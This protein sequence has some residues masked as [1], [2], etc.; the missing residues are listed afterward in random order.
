MSPPVVAD[1]ASFGDRTVVRGAARRAHAPTRWQAMRRV[2]RPGSLMPIRVL[3]PTY[4]NTLEERA[5]NL[6]GQKMKAAQLFYGDEVASA[7]CDDEQGDFLNDLILSVLKAERLERANAIFAAQNDLTA[8]PLSDVL[9]RRSLT[10]ASP[11]LNPFEAHT[12]S[13]WLAARHNA[14][15]GINRKSRVAAMQGQL[16]L[17]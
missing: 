3:F 12:W 16:S 13:E 10:A 8:S 2:Y 5:L 11:H 9:Y 14:L 15:P 7:L 6:L 1:R 17:F 4:E